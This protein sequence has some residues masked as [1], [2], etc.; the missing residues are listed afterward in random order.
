MNKQE[1]DLLYI[2]T[3]SADQNPILL[4]IVF[5]VRSNRPK[6]FKENGTETIYNNIG[7]ETNQY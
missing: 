3:L 7:K 2:G 1:Y 4:Q 6:G 5:S